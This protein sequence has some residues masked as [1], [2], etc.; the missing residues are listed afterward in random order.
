[1]N[2]SLTTLINNAIK[3]QQKDEPRDYIG[4]SSI[5]HP[6]LR[7]IWYGYHGT[8]YQATER[9]N[10]TFEIGKRLETMLL[11][12]LDM[13]SI[14]VVRP[15]IENHWLRCYC[16]EL[17]RFA[18][19]MDAML[20][21]PGGEIVVIDI[22]SA[23]NSE[24]Q[25]FKK[26]GL[27]RWHDSYYAQLQAYMGMTGHKRAVLLV[28]NKDTSELHEEWVDYDEIYYMSLVEKA[29]TVA[30]SLEIPDRVN[31]NATFWLC[32]MCGY[33]GVCHG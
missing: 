22:K 26:H 3:H 21:L 12:Y 28:I 31:R 17:P 27:Q 29:R 14:K 16:K 6:C 32:Q 23:K 10:T 11:D 15:T 20:I 30:G 9:L 4:A 7:S 19:H 5:G 1:M 13:T 2:I 8:E 25:K 33:K 18:G 24:F